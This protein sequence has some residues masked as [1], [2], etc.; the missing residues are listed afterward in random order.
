M[1]SATAIGV[2]VET[3]REDEFGDLFEAFEVMRRSLQRR[4]ADVERAREAADDAR[5]DALAAKQ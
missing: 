5:L 4:I 2:R 1:R 3:D